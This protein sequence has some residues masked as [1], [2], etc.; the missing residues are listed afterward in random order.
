[1]KTAVCLKQA[2][3]EA[4]SLRQAY[5]AIENEIISFNKKKLTFN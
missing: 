4:L 3:F 1:M 2:Y 5:L